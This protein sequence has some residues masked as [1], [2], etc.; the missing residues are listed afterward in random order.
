VLIALVISV[1]AC[2]IVPPLFPGFGYERPGIQ[3]IRALRLEAADVYIRRL[4]SVLAMIRPF[5]FGNRALW[6]YSLPGEVGYDHSV[7]LLQAHGPEPRFASA[8][9]LR[10]LHRVHLLTRARRAGVEHCRFPG[11]PTQDRRRSHGEEMEAL[12]KI[13][14]PYTDAE[15]PAQ[16]GGR[17]K[18]NSTH[19]LPTCRASAKPQ[20]E[21]EHDIGTVRGLITAALFIAFLALCSGLQQ[22][23]PRRTSTSWHAC[24]SKTTRPSKDS[25]ARPM[26]LVGPVRHHP[27]DRKHPAC[28]WLL[29]WTSKPRTASEKIGGAPTQGTSGKDCA[30]TKIRCRNVLWLFLHH[31]VFGLL[32]LA[33]FPAWQ[34]RRHQRWTQAGH[35]NGRG[36]P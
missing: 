24:R 18:S 25:G 31:L 3:A 23:S 36:P 29:R 26:I 9:L 27:D 17:G 32:T 12:R 34:F 19:S 6:P 33:F 14:V 22:A 2:Q 5:R 16:R 28:L 4:P 15:H 10:R 13:G 8:A 11:W 1:G 30:S 35:T 20:G 21:P 7:P